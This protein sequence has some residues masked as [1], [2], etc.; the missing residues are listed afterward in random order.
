M[1]TDQA[2]KELE[3]N[4]KAQGIKVKNFAQVGY[5]YDN[6]VYVFS[7]LIPFNKLGVK[8]KVK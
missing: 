7:L 5:E 2:L 8:P 3:L 1:E 6:G 4:I